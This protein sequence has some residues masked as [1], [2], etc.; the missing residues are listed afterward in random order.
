MM[1][2]ACIYILGLHGFYTSKEVCFLITIDPVF[3]I[4]QKP[5]LQGVVWNL[6]HIHIQFCSKDSAVRTS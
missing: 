5:S 6:N 3:S 4:K 1:T 2:R